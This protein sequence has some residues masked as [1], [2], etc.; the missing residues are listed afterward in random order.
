[1]IIGGLQKLTLLDYPGKVA[2][3]VFLYGCDFRC[4]FCHNPGLVVRP[5]ENEVTADEL[6]E[7]LGRRRGILDGVCV[8]GGEPLLDP[9]LPGLLS[10]I[11]SFGL[12]VKLDTNGSFPE[13][14]EKVVEAGLADY[15]AMDVKSSPEGYPAAVGIKN[16]DTAPI[17]RSIKYLMSAKTE[18]EF[19]TTV[20]RELHTEREIR[21]IGEWIR[22]AKNAYLQ[23]FAD[24]GDLIGQ[25]FH[26][27]DADEMKRLCGILREYVPSAQLRGV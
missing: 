16:F 12:S 6:S 14:L 20:V 19:R 11:K 17:S 10:L 3:T 7:F 27:Y 5:A 26:P 25:G 22:G 4:P 8:T 2:C 9:G 24:S 23:Q 21:L 18:Y 15:V 13:R 1:M